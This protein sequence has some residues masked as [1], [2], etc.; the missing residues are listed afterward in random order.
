MDHARARATHEF[1]LRV[2]KLRDRAGLTQDAL[3]ALC[4]R[5]RSWIAELEGGGDPRLSDAL[6]LARRLADLVGGSSVAEML[7]GPEADE[8]VA[9]G[10]AE[11]RAERKAVPRPVRAG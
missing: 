3:A 1:G 9:V 6:T 11:A 8:I 4:G 2:R 7:L 10:H 5:S